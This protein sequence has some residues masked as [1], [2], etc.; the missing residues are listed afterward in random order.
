MNEGLRL[1]L[2]ADGQPAGINAF[3]DAGITLENE[4]TAPPRGFS[5][6]LSPGN[7]VTRFRLGQVR[8]RQDW[9]DDE[10][11]LD[12][13]FDEGG[14]LCRGVAPDAFPPAIYSLEVQIADLNPIDQPVDIEVHK[15]QIADVTLR[16]RTDPRRIELTTPADAF[17]T[18]IKRVVLNADSALDGESVPDWLS[19]PN[20]RP[21]RKA[22]L[23]NLLAKARAA[24]GP[25][26]GT[27]LIDRISNVFFAD[28]DRIYAKVSSALLTD[29]RTLS[30]DPT[31]PFFSEGS[32]HA[33]IHRQLLAEIPEPDAADFKLFSFRQEGNPSM[34]MVVAVPPGA[35]PAR[36]CYVDM[37]IDL[38]NPLQDVEGIV[39]H[40]GELLTPGKT[41]HLALASK[42]SSGPTA[43][44]LYYRVVQ[45]QRVGA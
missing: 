16:F 40:L 39:I 31:Q 35:D 10:F 45:V 11:D 9:Q 28:V 29:L 38:G 7:D 14:I 30:A 13:S 18:R 19:N 15:D 33:A 6:I 1:H 20:P 36:A 2:E 23:L 27:F 32:P 37:D 25:A 21:R 43:E 26:D 4:T 44:F 42:L 41:D 5:L 22:C 34:Q 12:L 17:D 24:E 8:Q 3:D